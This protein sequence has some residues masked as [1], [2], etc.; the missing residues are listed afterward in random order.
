M[1]PRSGSTWLTELMASA[2]GLGVPQEWF[3]ESFLRSNEPALGC[4]PP[5]LRGTLD[6]NDYLRSIV[7][8]GQG[9]AG[10][11]VS[12]FQAL[13][14]AELFEG[15]PEEGILDASFYL[16]RW[17]VIAQG[18]SLYRS[19]KSGRFHSYQTKPEEIR[20]FQEVKYDADEIAHW[21]RQ[22][23]E[24][25]DLFEKLFEKA[26][27]RPVPIFYEDLQQNPLGHLREIA[28]RIGVIGPDELP[29]SNLTLM[30]DDRSIDWARKFSRDLS[31]DLDRQI[32][33]GCEKL[34]A[35]RHCETARRA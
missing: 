14:L 12:I 9:V 18:I 35:V 22:I 8:E 34:Q 11:E 23:I 13:M 1:T 21:I 17:D 26:G 24:Y 31:D 2:G 33:E 20:S 30:R 4:R 16:R 29:A 3:N 6:I 10:A 25:E 7:D 27:L 15:A 28:E 32:G 5:L 19:A